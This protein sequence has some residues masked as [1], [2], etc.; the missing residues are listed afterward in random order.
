MDK[1]ELLESLSLQVDDICGVLGSASSELNRLLGENGDL[2]GEVE[3]LREMLC[4]I[5]RFEPAEGSF[6]AGI[7]K[8]ALEHG[9]VER[10]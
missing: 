8:K 9:R 6:A 1:G 2:R 3:Y 10:P 5:I 4:L 7:A